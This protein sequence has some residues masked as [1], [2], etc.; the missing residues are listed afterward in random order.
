[1]NYNNNASSV[2]VGVLL[3]GVVGATTMLL[4]APQSGKDTR[5]KIQQK[6]IELR[7]QAAD[8]AETAVSQLRSG[9]KRVTVVGRRQIREM[10][11]QGK[12]MALEQLDR[13]S[14]MVQ[15]GKNAI[16]NSEAS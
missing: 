4:L 14:G 1:M 12:D 3:G 8:V 13:V 10:K 9:A 15:S 2:L 5:A 6:S 11:K 16:R 7:D